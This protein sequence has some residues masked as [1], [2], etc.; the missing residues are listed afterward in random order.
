MSDTNADYYFLRGGG[1]MGELIR[2]KDWSKTSLGDPADWPQ[3]LRTMVAVMLDNPF[4]MY[5]AWGNEY[6]QLYND[7]YR[8]I[9]GAS[10]HPQAL[11]ISTRETFS[12]IWDNI[13]GSMFDDV[14][15]GK[16]VG[17]ADLMLPLNRN[18]FVEECY[19][20]FAYSPIRLDDGT[21]GGVLVTVIETTS[22]K[23][24]QQQL[25]E[26]QYQLQFA[27]ESAEL[28]TWDYNPATNR[29]T[30][31]N[32]LKE[33]FG[34][35]A[36]NDIELQHA[37][38]A[39]AQKDRNRIV[40]AIQSALSYASGGSYNE[41][42]SIINPHTQKEIIINAKGKVWFD[43][44]KIAYRFNGVM[45]DVTDTVLA[46][47][48]I[49]ESEKR[50]KLM[51][52][53]SDV[54][55]AVGDE[56]SNATYFNK[57]W[58]TLTGR[59]MEDL[60]KFGWVDL[61]HIDD[62]ETY[63]NIYLTAFEKKIP[64]TGEFRVL[65]SDGKYCHLLAKGVPRFL[66]NGSF[67]GYIS[68]CVDITE[69]I[70][71][72][73]R[74]RESEEQFSTL[75]D[76]MEN[77]AWL[78]DG[79]GSIYWYN[80]RWLEYSGLTLE[81]MQGWGWQKVH[82]P[83]HVERV[84]EISKKIWHVNETFELT[85]PLRRHDG[86]YRWFLTRGYPVTN[87][88][89]K[90]IRWIGTNTDIN[91]QKKAE[92]LLRESEEQ[93]EFLLKLSD[94]LRQQSNPDDI[95]EAVIKIA[96]D[97]LEV[98]WCHF[99]I[100]EEDN[101]I[102]QRDAVR[103]TLPSLVG[104]Y[105]LSNYPLFKAILDDGHPLVVDNVHT[106]QILDAALKQHFVHLQN[107][108]FINVPV[109]KNG[110]PVAMLSFVQSEARNWTDGEVQLTIAIAERTWA[111]LERTKAEKTLLK[112]EEKYRTL[113]NSI[114]QGFLLGE[115]IRNND[116]KGIDYYVHE[117][118]ATYEKQTGINIELVLGK[119]VLQAF[120]TIDKWW[121]ET[122]ASVVD[123]QYPV[124]FEKFFEFTNRWFEIKAS[125]AG[126]EMF[127]ILFTDITER[128]LA[129][130]KIKESEE[131]FRSLAQTLPQLVWITDAQG[132][133]E[134]ASNKWKEYSG[135]E[136]DGEQGWREIVHPDD[137]DN[138][139]AAWLRSLNTGNIYS[140]NVRLKSKYGE[141]RWHAVK[142]EPVLDTENKI[143]KWVGSFTDI[144][145]EKTF[146][147]EL[148][149]QVIERT[150]ALTKNNIEL[151]NRTIQL[152]EAQQLAHIG[153]WEWDV[154]TNEINWS[155][156]LFRIFGLTPHEFKADYENYLKYI[157]ADDREYVDAI[158]QQ[159]FKDHQ[160]YTF[161]HKVVWPDGEVRILS[162]TGKVI[163]DD[164]GNVIKMSGTAQDVTAQ[165]KYEEELKI[166][167]ERFFKIF[168]SNPIPMSL[169]EIKTNK[170]K[171]AN[172]LFYNAFGYYK[173]EV[174]GN[175]SE[176]LN[177]MS[178]KEYKRVIDLIFGYLHENR[179]LEEVQA[180]PKEETEALLLRL[181]QS[182]K[183]KD[184]EIC[185]TRKNGEEFPAIV[186]FEVIRIGTESYT[187]T[188]YQDIT[189]R[190][191]SETLL[192]NQNDQLEKMNKELESFAYVSSHDLQEP[193][194]KIQTFASRIKE[195]E[196]N[197]LSDA[198][199]DM[200][201]RMQNAAKRMQTLIQDLLAYSRTNTTEHKLEATNLNEII[202]E[203]KDDLQEEL[204]EKHATIEANQLGEADIIPF[205]FKQL[206]HNLIINS[207]KF[208]RPNHPP[209]IQI[210]SEIVNGIKFNNQ[211]I[212]PQNKYC[213][214][215]VTDNGIGFEEQYSEKIFE[216]FQ[217]LHGRNEYNGTG[218][219]LSIV[220]K[221]VQNHNGIIT[222][223]GEPNKG[224]TFDIYIP[225][226]A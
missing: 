7:G 190:K 61:V 50:F 168:D 62:R 163:T 130:E 80:K 149:E 185:Y 134:F 105:P 201:N 63:V 73:Q 106:T 98:D 107:I 19:F 14:M 162:A 211:K 132:N 119:T 199:K 54:L 154:P 186:S 96:L 210:K 43:D 99:C 11:G 155:D 172:N 139:N 157:H 160:S 94:I 46:R 224:A 226:L 217:R 104:L 93:K 16:A 142:G 147:K 133:Q 193:L 213:R 87:E 66:P 127:T 103:G 84:L 136:T 97:F 42:Y 180:L 95:E 100:I 47:K 158:V 10:K 12:E 44:N 178:A 77:L 183:M 206:M 173:E 40:N 191:K 169:T 135:V 32:K 166:S 165:K 184:F 152:E 221:I 111:A 74:V 205:Q 208:S 161:F 55:I 26:Q 89:G 128:I 218:I 48:K 15:K 58:V 223:K 181:K 141:Y 225:H 189:E 37:T 121:I 108:A 176:E 88:E 195:K 81:E 30:A 52:E 70:K 68:S 3:T 21:V 182:G 53:E 197:N 220:K 174:I 113:F 125:P 2:A 200:F 90:I 112:S 49:E 4:G 129:I 23:K 120:P 65:N 27:I 22:K 209:L 110:K 18:G 35:A 82:H 76:N 28:G 214:I 56:S 109:I 41:E 118:N 83:D 86:E 137:Y 13:I 179:S 29:F 187:V 115:I 126:K 216:L 60:L 8:P 64:F 219:G 117:V 20:D 59:P 1:E 170:I 146:T 122:Y 215:T 85:F 177:L 159:A 145:A 9:L 17:F 151:E 78:A 6:I 114:D 203:V 72:E 167:E 198:G 124:R 91:E 92:E 188:S 138:I 196:E 75:A 57:A 175:S 164:D 69:R 207:L 131:R 24:A 33:L 204:K 79:E 116:G 31:N 71:T 194:R 150:A 212:S 51:S 45:Q 34:I 171:Y 144:H 148:E 67:V 102:I 192:K 156:E 39:I 38:N 36:E 25:A 101:L 143:I 222:A 140:F 153:S 202:A 123:N 5:I